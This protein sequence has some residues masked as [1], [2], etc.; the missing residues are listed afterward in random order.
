MIQMFIYLFIYYEIVLKV[1]NIKHKQS[2]EQKNTLTHT[3]DK[4]QI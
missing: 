3:R 4:G 1:Q 2:G